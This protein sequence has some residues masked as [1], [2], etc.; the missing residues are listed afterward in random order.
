[1]LKRK[2][3][4]LF[5]IICFG[6]IIIVLV[7]LPALIYAFGLFSFDLKEGSGNA[8]DIRLNDKVVDGKNHLSDYKGRFIII[9]FMEI[10]HDTIM[11]EISYDKINDDQFDVL[12]EVFEKF[13]EEKIFILTIIV[14]NCCTPDRD[15][16][17]HEIYDQSKIGWPIQPD[18]IPVIFQAYFH[19]IGNTDINIDSLLVEDPAVV[20]VNRDFDIVSVSGYVPYNTFEKIIIN[21]TEDNGAIDEEYLPIQ[22][23]RS[24]RLRLVEAY[25]TVVIFGFLSSI[26]PCCLAMLFVTIITLEGLLRNWHITS[27]GRK[28]KARGVLELKG[29]D[30]RERIIVGLGFCIGMGLL[31]FIIGLGASSLISFIPHFKD[32]FKMLIGG[33]IILLGL[34]LVGAGG[35]IRYL[36][37]FLKKSKHEHCHHSHRSKHVDDEHIHNVG[38]DEKKFHQHQ[39][40]AESEKSDN[41]EGPFGDCDCHEDQ[42]KKRTD[43]FFRHLRKLPLWAASVIG[44]IFFGILEV[45]GDTFLILPSILILVSFK[46]PVFL[47]ALF[48]FIFGLSKGSIIVPFLA[49]IGF[50]R[51][52]FDSERFKKKMRIGTIVLG[53]ILT[54]WGAYLIWVYSI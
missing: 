23:E 14:P 4:S 46:T 48:M 38:D 20:M 44:G 13:D 52:V 33:I 6:I 47:I 42:K 43:N 35:W 21:H 10:T 17:I 40:S 1:M 28:F 29:N 50:I 15:T 34:R 18:D 19:Y 27:S 25:V 39:D 24:D 9:H 51:R 3:G 30:L 11:N 49:G 32:I 16:W 41:H 53:C 2:S 8:P 7:S 26:D 45:P 5:I 31:F 22:L 12:V 36:V 37:P 54:L